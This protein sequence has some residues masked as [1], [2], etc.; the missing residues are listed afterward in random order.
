MTTPT[1]N[2]QPA[3]NSAPEPLAGYAL[4]FDGEP[5]KKSCEPCGDYYHYQ[6]YSNHEYGC[7]WNDGNNSMQNLPNFPFKNG[8]K[9]FSLHYGYTIDWEAEAKRD[10]AEHAICQ[11]LGRGKCYSHCWQNCD[12][13]VV[14]DEY[15][16]DCKKALE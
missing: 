8:C 7:N 11:Y 3:Q 15:T 1:K 9:H 13:A 12:S 4:A 6:E 2:E 16:R 5:I 14:V 10:D